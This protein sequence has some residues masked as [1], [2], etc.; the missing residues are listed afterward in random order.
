MKKIFIFVSPLLE[1]PS[2]FSFPSSTLHQYCH[3][4]P[5]HLLYKMG[6]ILLGSL[7]C[8]LFSSSHFLTPTDVCSTVLFYIFW[9]L[10]LPSLHPSISPSIHLYFY[11]L[12]SPILQP[13]TIQ[14]TNWPFG[15]VNLEYSANGFKSL[16]IKP[17]PVEGIS[18]MITGEWGKYLG[19]NI[20]WI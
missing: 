13:T 9:S 12:I 1:F 8:S 3:G 20:W 2:A 15:Q 10:S 7:S 6:P 11:P 18:G 14:P 19:R 17:S 4:H 16:N 5:H